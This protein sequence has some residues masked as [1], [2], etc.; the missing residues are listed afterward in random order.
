[1]CVCLRYKKKKSS[2]H[3][4]MIHTNV[5]TPCIYSLTYLHI[6]LLWMGYEW[7]VRWLMFVYLFVCV[8]VLDIFIPTEWTLFLLKKD[9]HTWIHDLLLHL[10]LPVQYL[11]LVYVCLRSHTT[12]LDILNVGIVFGQGINV[13][14]ELFHRREWYHQWTARRLLELSC[15]GVFEIEHLF[16][17]HK[18]VGRVSDPAT[19][20]L[21][22]TVYDFIPRS[23][24]GTVTNAFRF[25]LNHCVWSV[26][27]SVFLLYCTWFWLGWSSLF[28]HLGVS[29]VSVCFLEIINYVEHYGLERSDDEPV[30][31]HHS[32]DAPLAVSSLILFKLPLHSD[33]H[34]R[35][36]KPY[37]ELIARPHARQLP[38]SYPVMIL[39]ALF[40][41]L[42]FFIT[43]EPDVN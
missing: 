3:L 2:T 33:H 23:I 4:E 16:G 26:V 6:F 1:M 7:G 24:R 14:H 25:N 40:P 36:L 27:R 22:M 5:L 17:H 43:H 19:A 29:G 28:F 20:P 12:C 42:F 13:A 32:W 41:S 35:C 38:C 9:T 21:G 11:C 37:P 18:N 39:I 8:P 15:Y 34:M 10:W 30:G 31:E